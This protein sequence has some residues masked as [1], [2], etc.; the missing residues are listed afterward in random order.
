[1]LSTAAA[2]ASRSGDASITFDS[3]LDQAIAALQ[4]SEGGT[5]AAA[6]PLASHTA[7]PHLPQEV[8]ACGGGR[9]RVD[10]CIEI[11]R[12]VIPHPT[13]DNTHPTNPTQPNQPNRL[14]R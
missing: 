2:D 8:D 9:Q 11:C 1:M 14:E 6:R 12:L 13:R 10:V 4:L 7:A 3:E 5:G